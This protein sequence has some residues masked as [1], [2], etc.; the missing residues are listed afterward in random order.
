MQSDGHQ[1][2]LRAHWFWQ[3]LCAKK[4]PN[5]S[6]LM[7]KFEVSRPTAERL[8]ELLKNDY[9][10][11]IS[12]DEQHRGYVLDD[13]DWQ[14]PFL[15]VSTDELFAIAFARQHL[16]Q[17][18]EGFLSGL[19]SAYWERMV[20]ELEEKIPKELLDE[21][22]YSV[23]DPRVAPSVD[24]VLQLVLKALVERKRLKM[25][26]RSAWSDDFKEREISPWHLRF[27]EG[28][29]YLWAYCHLREEP[30]LFQ[31]LGIESP[32][33]TKNEYREKPSD[34]AQVY[35]QAG[36]GKFF[37]EKPFEVKVQIFPPRSRYVAKER[38]HPEQRDVVF[39]DDS[40]ER[41][42][43]AT[44]IREVAWH[45]LYLG[46]AA[47]VISPK[48]LKEEMARQARAILANHV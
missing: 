21:S 32:K 8:I 42:F 6:K 11:P 24:K 33:L 25:G 10:A 23:S 41:T 34:F 29:L 20:K 2:F 3:Q 39:K 1:F 7:E 31:V 13:P 17:A 26:Y 40:L 14:L 19:L 4:Y 48:E 12:Y 30:R 38:W 22:L 5:T 35:L 28:R 46:D 27:A 9:Y 36:V 16:Q 43:L 45:L 15:P 37:T 47:K 44:S 18:S